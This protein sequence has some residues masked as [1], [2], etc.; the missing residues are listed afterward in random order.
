MCENNRK[1]IY[2]PCLS[3]LLLI[4]YAAISIVIKIPV[5]TLVGMHQL[6]KFG[7]G[8]FMWWVVAK[9]TAMNL[10]WSTGALL[11]RMAEHWRLSGDLKYPYRVVDLTGKFVCLVWYIY[12]LLP[13][14]RHILLILIRMNICVVCNGYCLG[15]F[16]TKK[17]V[18]NFLLPSFGRACVVANDKLFVI[19]G[20]EGDFMPKP[21]SP[22]FKCARRHEVRMCFLVNIEPWNIRVLNVHD[23]YFV[24]NICI[25]LC[26]VTYNIKHT[27]ILN[28]HVCSLIK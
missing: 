6:L 22:I 8:G 9:K 21:G 1:F 2:T 5:L 24:T 10:D 19:G 16:T 18:N 27:D 11:W 7:A 25:W 17:N 14:A 13:I 23:I 3:W 20:Q 28:T 26:L 4:L 15:F 12:M